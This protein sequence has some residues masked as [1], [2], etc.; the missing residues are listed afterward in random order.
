MFEEFK[1]FAIKGNAM[2]LAIGVI[3][4]GAFQKIVDSIVGDLLMPIIG[5]VMGSKDFTSIQ[6]GSIMI[7]KFIQ[8]CFNFVIIAFVLFLIVKALNKAGAGDNK[9][10]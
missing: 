5:M 1:E 4:G 8:A 9:P 7:G 3:I 2:A 10:A 6:I